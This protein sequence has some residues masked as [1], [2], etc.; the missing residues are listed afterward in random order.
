MTTSEEATLQ[1][2]I[3]RA[4]KIGKRHGENAAEYVAQYAWGGRHTGDSEAAAR[5]F[6]RM[7]EE[8]DPVLFDM[9]RAPDLSGEFADTMTPG[10]LMFDCF[11]RDEDIEL[12][13]DSEDDVCTAY[14][15]EA[16]NG[17]W[18]RLE[19]SAANLLER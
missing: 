12:F 10:Q 16:S 6:L 4:E 2:A 19:E 1:E 11:D 8:G 18:Q 15:C 17:F 7:A 3:R 9:Y 5:E 14:E 13:A